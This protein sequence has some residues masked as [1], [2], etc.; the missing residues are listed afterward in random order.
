MLVSGPALVL[1]HPLIVAMLSHARREDP[2]EA[3]GLLLGTEIDATRRQTQDVTLET[4]R[5][6][7]VL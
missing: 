5:G 2:R 3:C 7:V 6:R 1:P 4:P